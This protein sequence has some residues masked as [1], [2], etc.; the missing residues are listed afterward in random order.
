[1]QLKSANKSASDNGTGGSKTSD[2]SNAKAQT[3]D[4]NSGGGN[5]VTVAG[6][7]A[8]NVVTTGSEASVSEVPSGETFPTSPSAGQ[9]FRLVAPV[10]VLHNEP[11]HPGFYYWGAGDSTWKEIA[12][13]TSFPGSPTTGDLFRLTAPSG[14]NGPSI[15]R[16]DGSNWV[17]VS[18]GT[19]SVTGTAGAL[20]LTTQANTDTTAK[21]TGKATEAGTVGIGAGVAVNKVD[22]TNLA[23]TGHTT[24]SSK[25]L[26][27]EATMR[28]TGE[29]PVQ[30]YTSSTGEWKSIESGD[31]FPESPG[32]KDLFQLTKAVAA[33]T[34][35]KGTSEDLSTGKLTVQSTDEFGTKG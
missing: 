19:T 17:R 10:S 29:D 2:T 28:N 23:T 35:V 22:I 26:D 15:Y 16:F 6:A 18:F 14:P 1:D 3:S 4:K 31:S 27:I 7:A 12:E 8:I 13:G 25:G 9:I 21:G 30:Q 24:I 33:T 11:T 20:T 34:A 32:D 5:T